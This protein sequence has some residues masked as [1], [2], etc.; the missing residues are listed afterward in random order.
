VLLVMSGLFPAPQAWGQFYIGGSVGKSDFDD[1]NAVPDLITSGT[2]DGKDSGFKIF[3]GYQFNQHFGVEI[4]YVDLG[5]AK[6]SGTFGALPVTGGSVDT[7]GLNMSIVGTLPLNPS[8]ELFGK[9]GLFAWEAKAHDTTGGVP[10]SGMDD[11][12]DVSF[13]IGVSF[14]ISKNVSIRAEWER[15]NAVDSIDFL[16][17]GVAFKF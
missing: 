7:S 9:V 2:V 6:Y 1:G 3:G 15:F 10:F 8:F 17:L 4:A 14:N 13:G 12:A 11:G 16:S 5:K